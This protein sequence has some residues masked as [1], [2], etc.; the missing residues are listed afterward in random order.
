MDLIYYV[1]IIDFL[2]NY[3]VMKKLETFWR[4]LRHDTKL[5]SAI[6]PRDYANRFYEFIEDSVDPLPQKKLNR[7][8]ETTLT[9]KI[10][11]TE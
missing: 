3:S 8:I 6:P 9:R 2:T 4:S 11:K 1:G 7:R 5:V 10:I